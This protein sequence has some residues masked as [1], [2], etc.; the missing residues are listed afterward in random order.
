MDIFTHYEAKW[1]KKSTKKKKDKNKKKT[2]PHKTH[3]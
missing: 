2:A 3:G 1:R